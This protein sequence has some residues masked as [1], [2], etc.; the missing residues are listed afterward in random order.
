MN[1]EN[2]WKE[3]D[4]TLYRQLAPVAVPVRAEQLA[5][6]LTLMPFAP[7][8]DFV[9]VELA[10]GEGDYSAALLDAFPKAKVIA[11]DGSQEMRQRAVRRLS[12]FGQRAAV[13]P[14]D[15]LKTDWLKALASVDCVFSSLCI[16][17]LDAKGKRRLFKKIFEKLS[18]RGVLLIADLVEPQR[19]EARALFADGWDFSTRRQ[20]LA[21]AQ[22]AALYEKFVQARWNYYRYPDPYDTPSPLFDQLLWLKEAR[23]EAVDCFWMQAGHAIYGGYKQRD[24]LPQKTLSFQTALTTAQKAL[25]PSPQPSPTRGDLRRG[26]P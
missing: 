14:F 22:S 15:I 25:P 26:F 7:Q 6:L 10:C 8:E 16:H 12:P 2:A 19:T 13:Q 4:S 1:K 9:A 5:T 17:H 20:S 21:L 18:P 23:F 24:Q 11:L 3:D